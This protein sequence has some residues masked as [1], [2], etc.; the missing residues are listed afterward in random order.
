MQDPIV[1]FDLETGG[2]EP[3]QPNIQIAAVAVAGGE[4]LGTFERK[5]RFEVAACNP[6]ALRLNDYREE[7]WQNAVSE[8]E[9]MADFAHFLGRYKSVQ[10]LSKAGK[11]YK[12]A[13]GGGHNVARFDVD[14]IMAAGKA[15]DIFMPLDYQVL[16]TYQAAVWYFAANP[17]WP[18]NLKLPTLCKH[19]GIEA[20]PAHEA[21]ADVRASIAIGRRLVRIFQKE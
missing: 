5:I 11:P 13:R 15:H 21:L 18:E 9:A 19:F 6:E 2:V 10:K 12:V 8:R 3:A 16:D 17:P 7:L 14:R 20:G 4:E 1:F